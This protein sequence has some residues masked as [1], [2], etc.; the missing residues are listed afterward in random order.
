[1]VN[2]QNIKAEMTRRNLNQIKLSKELGVSFR[3]INLKLSGKRKFTADE[4][5]SISKILKVDIS[6]FFESNV[7]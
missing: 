4:L 2:L 7:N 3:T 6:I 1:M 5:Y